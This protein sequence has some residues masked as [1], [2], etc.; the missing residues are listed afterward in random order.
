MEPL[1]TFTLL[2]VPITGGEA[3]LLSFL[4]GNA[5]EVHRLPGA[6]VVQWYSLA[7]KSVSFDEK[8]FK[9]YHYLQ[10]P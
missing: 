3:K 2:H 9:L 1:L 5:P 4:R 8:N 6:V 10:E 7:L